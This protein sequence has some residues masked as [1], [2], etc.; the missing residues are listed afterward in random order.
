VVAWLTV[1]IE[2]DFLEENPELMLSEIPES[3][4]I[5]RLL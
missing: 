4:E 1:D 2:D 3:D 5:L